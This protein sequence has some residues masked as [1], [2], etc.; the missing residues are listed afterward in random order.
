MGKVVRV[1]DGTA[2]Q[3]LAI[4]TPVGAQG[5]T[6][7]QGATGT[8]GTTGAQGTTGPQGTTGTQGATGTQGTTGAQGATGAQG[9]TGQAAL[10]NSS[11]NSNITLV[12]ANRY[13]VD[14]TAARSLTL[15]VS[16][17]VGDE[18]QVLDAS[19]TAGTYNITIVSGGKING[20]TQDAT[21]DV[22]GVAA[23]F[24]YTGSTYGW[25]MG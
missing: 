22:N 9:T 11:I 14:T 4:S 18:V 2:W 25:R 20:T 15:P 13:F 5:T 19:G 16:P 3:D 8:Q 1:Y 24:V 10:T 17:S 7:T 12:A 6:G 21:L 23:V